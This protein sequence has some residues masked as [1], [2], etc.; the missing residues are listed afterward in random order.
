MTLKELLIANK[1]NVLDSKKE[2]KEGFLYIK[3]LNS[4]VK[5]ID[6]GYDVVLEIIEM[7]KALSPEKVFQ[8]KLHACIN[9][10]PEF[11][12]KELLNAYNLATPEQLIKE[13][14]TETEISFIATRILEIGGY[15]GSCVGAVEEIK[16]L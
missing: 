1:K 7:E 4:K 11:A 13:I 12:D 10:M 16:K 6:I 14:F 2:I 15:D 8:S 9:G 5:I 3:R